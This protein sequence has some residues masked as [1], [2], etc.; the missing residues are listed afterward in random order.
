MASASIEADTAHAGLYQYHFS[1]VSDANY[2]HDK[3]KHVPIVVEQRVH[4]RPNA[5]FVHPGKTYSYCSRE[6]DGEEVIPIALEGA[7]PF[8]VEVSIKHHS[9]RLGQPRT[10]T[11]PNI[12]SHN[13][14]LRI[15]HRVLELGNSVVSIR[16]VRD[17][18]NCERT[19]DQNSPRVQISVHDAPSIT[20]LETRTDFC[21]GERLAY[22]L[23]GKVPFS[24]YYTFNNQARKASSPDTT[25]R[26]LAELPGNFAITGVSDSAS[27]CKAATNLSATIHPL[28]SVRIS[29][30]KSER[31]SI[32]EGSE[33]DILFEFT[34]TPPFEVTYTRSTN[35]KPGHRSKVLETR[36]VHS[37]EYSLRVKASEEGTYEAVALRD[38]WCSFPSAADSQR[39]KG[40][41]LLK[42]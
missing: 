10:V 22:M 6:E 7:P 28:P 31:V 5:R 1:E 32:R 8:T 2:D 24:V 25:F 23:S 4:S 16:K 29:K 30:G 3:K 41:K 35:E 13:H 15:P 12:G 39:G 20:P 11:I 37:E 40:Q 21:V 34:G 18:R 27:Q 17:S 9:G 36:V 33:T 19:L 14:E 42:Y 38:K 26:R